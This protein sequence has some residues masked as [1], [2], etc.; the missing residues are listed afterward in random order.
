MDLSETQD[1]KIVAT[2][3]RLN[4]GQVKS[5]R[6]RIATGWSIPTVLERQRFEQ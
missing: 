3:D 5:R 1:V 2:V 4:D 6:P